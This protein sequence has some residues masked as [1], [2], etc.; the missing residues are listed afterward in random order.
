M[1]RDA[2]KQLS[3]D[4]HS[5]DERQED[6]P[7]VG[8]QKAD[9]AVLATRQIRG[10]PKRASVASIPQPAPTE[11]SSTK[12]GGFS[13]FGTTSSSFSGFGTTTTTATTAIS[14]P[15]ATTTQTNTA[16]SLTSLLSSH[17]PPAQ[18]FSSASSASTSTFASPFSTSATANVF[19]PTPD[20]T[21]P[22]PPAQKD[23]NSADPHELKY[24]TSLRGLNESLRA[25]VGKAIDDDPFAD[26]SIF[27]ERYKSLRAD[28]QKQFDDKP[29]PTSTA[30]TTAAPAAAPAAPVTKTFSMPAP[31]KEGFS[32]FG[33][34][35]IPAPT[36][37]TPSTT[38]SAGGFKPTLTP[39][40]SAP[41]PFSTVFG[42]SSNK[43]TTSTIPIS[44]GAKPTDSTT[45]TTTTSSS[46]FA[47]K[48]AE[49]P[50]EPA[51]APNPF[52]PS[53][54]APK[55]PT[56]KWG[57]K[58]DSITQ[59]ESEKPAM[60]FGSSATTTTPSF[61][62]GTSSS[63][64]FSITGAAN[65]TN[66]APATTGRFAGFTG[67]GRPPST[68]TSFGFTPSLIA[69][70]TAPGLGLTPSSSTLTPTASES[71][72]GGGAAAEAS[73]GGDGGDVAN[74]DA[75][76]K[77]IAESFLMNVDNKHDQEGAGEEDEETMHHVKLKA[78]VM[79]DDK[80]A[81]SW[82]E[83]G[84]GVLRIKKHKETG[85]RRVLL[86]SSSTGQILINFTFHSAFKPTLKGKN[87]TFLGHDTKGNSKMY[88][89]KLQT[90]EQA[91]QLAEALDQEIKAKEESS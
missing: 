45:T 78:Y 54:M 84:Y 29:A 38:P 74:D 37:T 57:V 50:K 55:P 64:S 44:L 6:T 32:P 4:D 33:G 36:D 21:A 70:P 2:E 34:M 63:S 30:I 89:L 19:M 90:Q 28:I 12:F 15:F 24:Y 3:K 35:K 69:P 52:A 40:S 9:D 39:S 86:R 26:I 77:N 1:K 7:Q 81:K 62:F 91:T 25:A 22:Q 43:A 87:V 13:G 85:S 53:L 16:K 73:G 72:T 11:A 65:S 5:D 61:T 20:S 31:P 58:S 10:L 42:A 49:G 71:S 23:T 60:T 67:F 82:V 56:I 47:L 68:S 75:P 41:S 66:A 46:L 83:L 17:N 8:F 51:A 76:K 27:L 14:N 48:P 79:K 88:T 59:P 18:S 80:G